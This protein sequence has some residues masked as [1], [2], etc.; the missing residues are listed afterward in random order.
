ME[1]KT[2]KEIPTIAIMYDFDKTLCTTDMQNYALIPSLG[3]EN[4]AFWAETQLLAQNTPMDMVLAYMYNILAHSKAMGKPVGKEDFA[5]FGK[6]IKYYEGVESWFER[7]NQFGLSKGVNV[8][9][10]VISSGI[11]EIIDGTSIRKYFKRVYACEYLYDENGFACWPSMAVNYTGK[12]QFLFRINKQSLDIFDDKG[13]NKFVPMEERTV[14]FRNMIY[15]GDGITDVP[16]MK[17]V[18]SNGGCSVGVYTSMK[19]ST[20]KLL[21]ADKRVDFIFEADY[22]EDG[23]LEK[24]I[25]NVISKMALNDDLIR[26]SLYQEKN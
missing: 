8:E 1:K 25:K 19:S 2:G 26:L 24:C 13:I 11:K 17:L 6:S 22:R 10:Y 9:H 3:I 12:T 14:P 20:C 16:C 7:I 15:I 18:K 5:Q 4:D 23:Q 21:I